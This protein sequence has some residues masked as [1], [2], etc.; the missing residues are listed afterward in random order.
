MCGNLAAFSFGTEIMELLARVPVLESVQSHSE[1][2][3]FLS[4]FLSFFFC[5]FVL[6]EKI[7]NKC[8]ENSKRDWTLCSTATNCLLST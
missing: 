5:L 2:S 7:T 8:L 4:F 3:N 1:F 6:R